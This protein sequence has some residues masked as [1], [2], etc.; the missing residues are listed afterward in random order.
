MSKPIAPAKGIAFAFPD[1][2]NTPAPPSSPVPIPYPNVAQLNQATGIT[3][4][5]DKELKVG[6]DYVLLLDSEVS[7]SVGDEAGSAGGTKG[8]CKITGASRS[9]VY[10]PNKKGLARFLDTTDQNDGNAQGMLLSAF[11]TVLVGD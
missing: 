3:D 5:S 1:V 2:C 4:E 10:G 8:A 11:P 6:G 7:T 9:V